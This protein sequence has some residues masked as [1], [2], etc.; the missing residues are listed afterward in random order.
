MFKERATGAAAAAAAAVAAMVQW[1]VVH[2]DR[3]SGHRLYAYSTELCRE[4][5]AGRAPASPPDERGNT[6]K[7][8][9]LPWP[10]EPTGL[11]GTLSATSTARRDLVRKAA[12]PW[13]S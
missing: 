5:R 7:K 9:L 3:P 1:S 8:T 10:S 6:K 11:G 13:P 12:L 4:D 2:T